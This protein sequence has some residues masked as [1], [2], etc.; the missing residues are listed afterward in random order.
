MCDKRATCRVFGKRSILYIYGILPLLVLMLVTSPPAAAGQCSSEAVDLDIQLQDIVT[1]AQALSLST[2]GVDRRGEGQQVA[3]LILANNTDQPIDD[4]YFYIEVKN[5]SAGVIAELDQRQGRPF[6]LPP[7]LIRATNNDIQNGIPG[8]DESL[9]FEGGLTN[10]GEEFINDLEGQTRLPDDVYT[11]TLQI[12]QNAN[13]LNGGRCVATAT[14]AVGEEPMSNVR[15]VYMNS[16]GGEIGS[17]MDF[18]INTNQPQFDWSADGGESYRVVIVEAGDS[19][20]P[21]SLLND[22]RSTGPVLRDNQSVGNTLLPFEM[23]DVRLTGSSNF[24][25]PSSGVRQLES[26]NKY[27][28]QVTTLLR[29]PEGE[30][31]VDSE[32]WS[33]TIQD[34]GQST[35]TEN[36]QMTEQARQTLRTVLGEGQLMSLEDQNLELQSVVIDGQR[37]SGQEMIRK[38][39]EIVERA[40]RGEI[41][42]VNDED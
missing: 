20:S 9:S 11:L 3:S 4:L 15:D 16:P 39:K 30:E 41:T 35:D 27:Y 37:Y 1:K 40:R 32:I 25:Y 22:A 14:A 6:E 31:E 36:T 5:T 2:M 21:E 38:L 18:E 33:F 10:D 34:Q 26:G 28:W 19:E 17:G 29:T 13:R 23:A 7:R 24:Q 42:I 8:I 12:Y